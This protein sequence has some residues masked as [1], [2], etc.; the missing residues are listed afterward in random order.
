MS[1]SPAL[2]GRAHALCSLAQ[3]S[4]ANTQPNCSAH[5]WHTFS[6]FISLGWTPFFT[7]ISVSYRKGSFKKY[8]KNWFIWTSFAVSM[9]TF[10]QSHNSKFLWK[11]HLRNLMY[12]ALQTLK[13]Y[14]TNLT[15][16]NS[17]SVSNNQKKGEKILTG[18]YFHFKGSWHLS[19][20]EPSSTLLIFE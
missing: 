16:K 6:L 1:K 17:K 8:F 20:K 3:G 18:F 5:W 12:L 9:A 4:S 13:F 2:M 10:P 11:L 15:W 7:K 19:R 14:Y